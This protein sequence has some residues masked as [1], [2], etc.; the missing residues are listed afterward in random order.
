MH[1]SST[2]Y[3]NKHYLSIFA[4]KSKKIDIK[5]HKKQ[6]TV[7]SRHITYKQVFAPFKI[8]RRSEYF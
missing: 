6:K 2:F 5:L 8:A 7:Y 4:T 3:K 1:I